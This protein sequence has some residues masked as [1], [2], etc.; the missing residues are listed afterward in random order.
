MHH[1]HQNIFQN[2]NNASKHSPEA[3]GN[4]DQVHQSNNKPEA[5]KK[6]PQNFSSKTLLKRKDMEDI[7]CMI[8][9]ENL[10]DNN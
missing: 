5:R 1:P 10:V 9:I 6:T 7:F 3:S 8:C 2:V 4:K